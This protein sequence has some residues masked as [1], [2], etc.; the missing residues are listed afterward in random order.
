MK[1]CKK[2]KTK[3]VK[4]QL[5]DEGTQL[6]NT[7]IIKNKFNGNKLRICKECGKKFNWI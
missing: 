5:C 2:C 4:C 6:D 7:L 3:L 1:I